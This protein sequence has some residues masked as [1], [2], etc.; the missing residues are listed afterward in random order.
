MFTLIKKSSAEYFISSSEMGMVDNYP[1]LYYSIVTF[2]TEDYHD[3]LFKEFGIPFPEQL[4]MAVA[5][6]KA[7]YLAARY[8]AKNILKSYN[9]DESPGTAADRS[10]V[11]PSKWRGSLSHSREYAMAVITPDESGLTPGIDIEFFAPETM[12]ETA[13]LFAS[14]DEQKRLALSGMDYAT[15]LLIAFSAKE[16]LYKALYPETGRFFDFD[17]ARVC[18]IEP[19]HQCITLE[20]TQTLCASRAKGSQI[21]GYYDVSD[22]KVITI[23]A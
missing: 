17:A 18:K 12:Q 13:H 20:L 8:A 4:N 11:W 15:A 2:V 23:I 5:R 19:L 14:A 10:P 9:S 3:G 21:K 6:R 7:E 22:G 16:S 1:S